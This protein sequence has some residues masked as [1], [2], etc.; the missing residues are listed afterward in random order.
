MEPL[1]IKLLGL[2]A[3]SR[4]RLLLVSDSLLTA[5]PLGLSLGLV[6]WSGTGNE[7]DGVLMSASPTSVPRGRLLRTPLRRLIPAS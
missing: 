5:S 7:T 3:T 6:I 1:S 2:H 4:W